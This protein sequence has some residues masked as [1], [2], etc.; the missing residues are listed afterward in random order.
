MTFL[1][2]ANL[3]KKKLVI[4]WG[5]HETK[6]LIWDFIC[7]FCDF[8]WLLWL[9]WF[10]FY[11]CNF[12]CDFCHCCDFSCDFCHF[13][14]FFVT[15]MIFLLGVRDVFKFLGPSKPRWSD[16]QSNKQTNKHTNKQTN[17]QTNKTNIE[18]YYIDYLSAK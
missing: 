3:G 12:A 16:N 5:M 18:S 6:S 2:L 11:F 17:K 9:L 7:D 14:D 15:F 13:C 1:Y 10:F 8:L 4:F